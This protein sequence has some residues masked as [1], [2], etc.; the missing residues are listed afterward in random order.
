MSNKSVTPPSLTP[1]LSLSSLPGGG[2]TGRTTAHLMP[3]NDDCYSV[4]EQH[5]GRVTTAAVAASHVAAIDWVEAVV[6]RHS[7]ECD[8]ERVTGYLFPADSSRE[9]TLR[10]LQASTAVGLRGG[11]ALRRTER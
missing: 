6:R 8:F 11:V 4:L 5:F 7:I 3:W 10:L 2:Q 1:S 9:E